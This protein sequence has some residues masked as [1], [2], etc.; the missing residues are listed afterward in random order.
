MCFKPIASSLAFTQ[1]SQVVLHHCSV[2]WTVI[3][4]VEVVTEKATDISWGE[5]F[6][7]NCV[8]IEDA[9]INCK[10]DLEN[11][12]RNSADNLKSWLQ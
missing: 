10:P 3:T 7:V 1:Q 8:D 12:H 4:K 11:A 5:N 2:F 9:I 6:C